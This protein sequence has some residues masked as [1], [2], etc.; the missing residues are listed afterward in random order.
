MSRPSSHESDASNHDEEG[1]QYRRR[2]KSHYTSTS[3]HGQHEN[4]H[5]NNVDNHPGVH[6][7]LLLCHEAFTWLQ[8]A[9][10]HPWHSSI[11]FN[12]TTTCFPHWKG[13]VIL[14]QSPYH[15]NAFT[16]NFDWSHSCIPVDF[17]RE[18][19]A[20]IIQLIPRSCRIPHQVC[21]D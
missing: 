16:I 11:H 15:A 2:L 19:S 10:F 3:R 6:L 7:N 21:D 18:A 14:Q 4:T 8:L 12:S 13:L 1:S 17:T 5:V 20:H 9:K